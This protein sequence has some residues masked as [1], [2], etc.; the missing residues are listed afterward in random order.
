MQVCYFDEKSNYFLAENN[1]IGE[2]NMGVLLMHDLNYGL[3]DIMVQNNFV[4]TRKNLSTATS[5]IRA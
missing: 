5:L 2:G 4:D 1:V 3:E